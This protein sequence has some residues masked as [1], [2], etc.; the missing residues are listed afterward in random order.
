MASE[1]IL[2]TSKNWY[3]GLRSRT[4]YRFILPNKVK[5][6]TQKLRLQRRRGQVERDCRREPIV[7]FEV[8]R[9]ASP[10]RLAYWSMMTS[11][12]PG[13]IQRYRHRAVVKCVASSRQEFN[14]SNVI[15]SLVGVTTH[16]IAASS[17]NRD[18]QSRT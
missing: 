10:P 11:M 1:G 2:R 13:T 12:L 15:S 18:I 17:Y 3:L 9:L 8:V 16:T 7:F 5:S 6:L 4:L 14:I